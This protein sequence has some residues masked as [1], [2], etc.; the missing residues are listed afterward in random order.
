MT[1]SKNTKR[2]LLASVL[3][4]VLCCAMLI[5]STFAW[6]T[7]S[8]VNT[9]NKI[10][11]GNL[12]VD[13]VQ[14]GATLNDGQKAEIGGTIDKDTYYSLKNVEAPIFDY[15]LW[16]P[17]YTVCKVIGVKNTGNLALKFDLD[18]VSNGEL[19]ALADV[20]DIYGYTPVQAPTTGSLSEAFDGFDSFSDVLDNQEFITGFMPLGTLAD[21]VEQGLLEGELNNPQGAVYWVFV[22]HMREDAGNE[23]Q[24][25]SIGDTFDIVLN[26]AQNTVEED[27]FGNDDYDAGAAVTEEAELIEAVKNGGTVHLWSD[28]Q[29]TQRLTIENDVTL[30][31]AGKTITID[32]AYETAGSNDDVTPIRVGA[33]GSLTITGNGTIDASNASDYVVPVSVMAADGSVTIESGTI[34]TDTP[35][36]SCVFAMGGSVVINGGTF[37]NHSTAD[38]AYGGGDPLTLNLSN[39]T[40]G[41]IAV[42]GGTFVGRNPALGD[43]NRGGTFV[44]DGY[45]STEVADGRY[46]VA[47]EGNIPAIDSESLAKAL[48]DV[49]AGENIQLMPGEYTLPDGATI[50]QGV[51]LTGSG[52]DETKITV[53]VTK[54]GSSNMGLI[55]NQPGVAIRDMTILP[56]DAIRNWEYAG[57]IVVKEGDT[58]L[59][60]VK[61]S[62]NNGA[63]PV[64]VTG[65][66]FGQGDILT[67]SNSIITS[68]ARSLFIADGTNGKVI[69]DNCDITGVFSFNVNSGDSQNLEL[70]FR[71][72]A[73]HGWSSYGAIKSAVFAGT[74]FSQGGSDYNFLRPYIDTTWNNCTFGDGFRIGAGESGK[75]YAFTDCR[76]DDDTAVTA[77]NI[78]ERLLEMSGTDGNALRG[79]TVT[80]DGTQVTLQ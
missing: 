29:L 45:A 3:S 8:V 13:L 12:K 37:I 30:D 52:I 65:G 18:I 51:S 72:S 36:E 15:E 43:D 7:D 32:G 40:P 2:A 20:I 57:V 53:P 68:D 59:D 44:A 17:G 11:A 33:G 21:R 78:Q 26:A 60:N 10:Q 23:Y 19:G 47:E 58:V 77:G 49:K 80:V 69:V 4:V 54:D 35:N 55:I 75:A 64:L 56:N 1:S 22:F 6:F 71:D 79:C 24:G 16:E 46:I 5:G 62:S 31:L 66:A 38:Y 76:Y 70:E 14:L 41:T 39:G 50:P 27:G 48:Q 74:E 25:M 67:I 73:I 9:G 28:V 34:I 63:S 61:V 42:Y